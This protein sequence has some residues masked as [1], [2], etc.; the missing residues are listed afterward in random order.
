MLDCSSK[1]SV[2]NDVSARQNHK[3]KASLKDVENKGLKRVRACLNRIKCVCL[4]H[5][6]A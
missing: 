3:A 1:P 4:R 6:N 5:S 2:D